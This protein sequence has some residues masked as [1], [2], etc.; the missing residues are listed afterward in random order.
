MLCELYCVIPLPV[1]IYEGVCWMRNPYRLHR[2][3]KHKANTTTLTIYRQTRSMNIFIILQRPVYIHS[4]Q[5]RRFHLHTAT[6]NV[7]VY[8]RHGSLYPK[9]ATIH[10]YWC[11]A[12]SHAYFKHF[13]QG[14]R[15]R[16]VVWICENFAIGILV[17]QNIHFHILNS[18]INHIINTIVI[19]VQWIY[20][21]FFVC[22]HSNRCCCCL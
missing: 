5:Q 22:L 1:C 3:I 17:L 7:C 14:D 19:G 20:M 21:S 8:V 18:P 6:L 12:I 9:W 10:Y 4:R 13:S 2:E 16:A 11:D 15:C